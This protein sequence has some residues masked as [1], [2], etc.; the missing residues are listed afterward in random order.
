ML[1]RRYRTNQVANVH[2]LADHLMTNRL[3]LAHRRNAAHEANIE[4][5]TPKDER[6]HKCVEAGLY[7]RVGNIAPLYKTLA[8]EGELPHH[9]ATLLSTTRGTSK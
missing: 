8:N 9:L 6:A 1:A 5:A 3:A 2:H 7:C 4:V